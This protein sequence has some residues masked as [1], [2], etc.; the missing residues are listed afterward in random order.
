MNDFSS[1]FL[2]I[3]KYLLDKKLPSYHKII[4]LLDKA[5]EILE[6]EKTSYRECDF[7]NNAGSLLDFSKR[8]F[9]FIIVPDIHA[10]QDFLLNLLKFPVKNSDDFKDSSQTVFS[11]LEKKMIT[12]ICVGD[13]LHTEWKT[14]E[15]WLKAK[16]EL[17]SKN[18]TGESITEEMCANFNV[19]CA[20]MKLKILF[21]ENFHFLK[22]N[23]ENIL[24]SNADGNYPFRKFADEGK[25]TKTFVQNFYGDDVLYLIHYY[26][27]HLPLAAFG[28][29]FVVTHA[30]PY[31]FYTKNQIINAK[32][33]SGVIEGLTWTENDCAKNGSVQFLIDELC[34]KNS[35]AIYFAGHRPVRKKY[36]L[37][38]NGKLV[39]IHNPGEENVAFV[40]P[41]KDFNLEKDIISV[42]KF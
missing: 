36:S 10:R 37:R 41:D 21:C 29:N 9:P 18:F 27:K 24:N 35:N 12:I 30:E 26:E 3:E 23:H 40:F 22:G 19:L 31:D 42:K 5:S 6:N 7:E 39:Q 13:A 38:Q 34:G 17:D 33:I 4:N 1:D 16:K 2:E 25:M 32:N 15:R 28:K 8:N 11:L 20:L 14:K